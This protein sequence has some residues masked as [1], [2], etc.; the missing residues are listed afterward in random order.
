M[1]TFEEAKKIPLG[2]LFVDEN[3][4]T[5]SIEAI[6]PRAIVTELVD[7]QDPET[8]MLAYGEAEFPLAWDIIKP[9]P[10]PLGI[11]GLCIKD[12]DDEEES[13]HEGDL[14][15]LVKGYDKEYWTPVIINPETGEIFA[16][17]D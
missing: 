9:K 2:T 3:G 15:L 8:S 10:K 13:K 11:L 12:Y 6:V 14:G 5:Q 17:N 4:E 7:S 16:K 1:I